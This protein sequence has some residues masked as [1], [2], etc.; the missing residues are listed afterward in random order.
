MIGAVIG[1]FLNALIWRLHSGESM[2]GR[3][4]CPKCHQQIAWHDNIPVF[5]YLILGGKCRHCGKGISLQYPLV[6][7]TVAVLFVLGLNHELR[8]MNHEWGNG[9]ASFMIHNSLFILHLLRSWF[10]VAV[11]VLIF[12]YDLRWYLILDKVTIPASVI[13]FIFWLIENWQ[14]G[15]LLKIE[16]WQLEIAA[17]AF[18]VGIF[19]LQFVVSKGR[20]IGLGDV[21]LGLVM[22]LALGWPNIIGAIFIAYLLGAAVGLALMSFGKKELGSKLP[23]GTFLSVAT[24]VMMLWGDQIVNWYLGI[25]GF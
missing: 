21:K 16:N 18:G 1:S 19:G 5:S 3:S 15:N 12:I 17:L 13:L 11:M 10:I 8:I 20:W 4:A 14:T 7:L 6:E 23:F 22:A 9:F 2:L 24:I 25:I